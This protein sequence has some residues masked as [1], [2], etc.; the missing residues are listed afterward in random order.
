MGGLYDHTYLNA[1][2]HVQLV[3]QNLHQ[4]CYLRSNY[5][6]FIWIHLTKKRIYE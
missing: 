6:H 3:I 4:I 1:L 2:E 5:I